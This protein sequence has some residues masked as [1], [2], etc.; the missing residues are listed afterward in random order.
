MA[1]LVLFWGVGLVTGDGGEKMDRPSWVLT[2]TCVFAEC[3]VTG[4]HGGGDVFILTSGDL[5]KRV[6]HAQRSD[7]GRRLLGPVADVCWS[8]HLRWPKLVPNGFGV[9]KAGRNDRT[10]HALSAKE[11]ILIRIG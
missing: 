11:V 8:L 7:F 10:R 4:S 2:Q 3:G 1:H 9:N 6:D 5:F